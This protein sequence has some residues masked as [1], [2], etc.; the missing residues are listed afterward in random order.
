MTYDA[1]VKRVQYIGKSVEVRESLGFTS[2]PEWLT[3]LNIYCTS[4]YSCL[5]AAAFF[6]AQTVAWGIPRATRTY[7]VQQ[8]PAPGFY[9]GLRNSPSPEVRTLALLAG[10]DLR[11]MTGSNIRKVEEASGLSV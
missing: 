3:T 5:S 8:C 1:Q 9:T 4:N 7:F 2:T 6:S 10:R 11:T